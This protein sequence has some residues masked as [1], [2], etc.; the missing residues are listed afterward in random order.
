MRTWFVAVLVGALVTAAGCGGASGPKK[1][2]VSGSVQLD[3]QPLAEGDI[4]FIPEDKTAGAEG[5]KIKDGKYKMQAREGKNKVEITATRVVPGKKGPMG[6]ED[7]LESIVP[8]K[9]NT[10]STLS[11]DVGSGKTEHNFDLKK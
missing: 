8:E 9:Y 3:G 2:D 5:G 10:K 1:M 6:T 4:V 7:L 11:A